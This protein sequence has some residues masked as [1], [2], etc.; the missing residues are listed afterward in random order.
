MY[1]LNLQLGK[2][3]SVKKSLSLQEYM[4]S[5]YGYLL[6]RVGIG[7]RDGKYTDILLSYKVG[8]QMRQAHQSF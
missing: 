2:K 3:K 1:W 6:G 7:E 8:I 4:L 5:V